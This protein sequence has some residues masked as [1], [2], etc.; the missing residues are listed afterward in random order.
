MDTR[1]EEVRARQILDSRGRPTVEVDVGLTDGSVG[2]ASVPSGASTGTS[3]AH[4]LRDGDPAHYGGFGV[5][6]AVAHVNGE[7][8]VSV[9]GRDG[10]DQA[11]IDAALR[12]LDGTARLSRL[13]A[14]Q[15]PH[16]ARDPH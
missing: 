13:G 9:H 8:A 5:L 3:E 7:I 12:E 16:S 11:Q 10:R 2:R 15:I 14:H 1:I 4:E 6:K